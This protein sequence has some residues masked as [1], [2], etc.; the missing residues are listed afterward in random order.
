MYLR[1]YSKYS[2]MFVPE[3]NKIKLYGSRTKLNVFFVLF[4]YFIKGYEVRVETETLL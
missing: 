1:T 3:V 2:M 4:F